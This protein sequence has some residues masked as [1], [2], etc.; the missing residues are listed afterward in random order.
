MTAI[1]YSCGVWDPKVEQIRE[2]IITNNGKKNKLPQST[3]IL[4]LVYF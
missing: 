2:I 1:D 4:P 3:C